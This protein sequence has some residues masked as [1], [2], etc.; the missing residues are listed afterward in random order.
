MDIF[1]VF[2]EFLK[3]NNAYEN[4]IRNFKIT[5]WSFEFNLKE[6]AHWISIFHWGSSPEGGSYWYHLW[7]KWFDLA[8]TLNPEYINTCYEY[9]HP[10]KDKPLYDLLPKDQT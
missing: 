2:E 4:Y 1:D 9:P 8:K 5:D 7:C 3:V 10:I 6:I